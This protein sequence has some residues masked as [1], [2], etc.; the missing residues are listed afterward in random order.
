MALVYAVK[1][2]GNSNGRI[3]VFV[4]DPRPRQ[5]M[6]TV[7]LIDGAFTVNTNELTLRRHNIASNP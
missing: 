2:N 7:M 3:A 5:R 6:E 4:D 1:N